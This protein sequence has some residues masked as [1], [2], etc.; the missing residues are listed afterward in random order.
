MSPGQAY[1]RVRFSMTFR[2]YAV[3]EVLEIMQRDVLYVETEEL[4]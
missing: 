3:N 2:S 1:F 4:N